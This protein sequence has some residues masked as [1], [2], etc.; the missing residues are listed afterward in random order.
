MSGAELE[1]T[2]AG[3]QKTGYSPWKEDPLGTGEL[4]IAK[5]KER[6]WD[7]SIVDELAEDLEDS[8]KELLRGTVP[9]RL[10][11]EADTGSEP[12]VA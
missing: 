2:L 3:E 5:R 6:G 10:P 1:R 12:T 11:W 4:L 8:V 9:D 7:E